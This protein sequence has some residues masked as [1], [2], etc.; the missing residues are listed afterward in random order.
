MADRV[1]LARWVA[2]LELGE[3]AEGTPFSRD[4]PD[5]LAA[6]RH[7]LQG[8]GQPRHFS[9]E[10][11]V[12]ADRSGAVTLENMI[13]DAQQGAEGLYKASSKASFQMTSTAVTTGGTSTTLPYPATENW[14]KAI[15]GHNLW[16]SANVQVSAAADGALWF[17]MEMTL[18]AEDRYNFNPGQRDIATGI[19]DSDNGRFEITGLAHQ[20]M[21][22]A[23]LKRT[24]RWRSGQIAGGVTSGQPTDRQRKPDDNRRARN[25][26]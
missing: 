9:Y 1:A 7:F 6:Y 5:A 15:G 17:N 21:H 3:A 8:N 22:Y 10:R 20:Y 23:T 4:L 19:P 18:H 24:V 2:Q 12:Q 14:Q 11:Y 13:A 26:V 25:R 16:I